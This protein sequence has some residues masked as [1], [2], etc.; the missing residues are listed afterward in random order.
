VVL[1]EVKRDADEERGAEL[2]AC[3]SLAGVV[4][5]FPLTV[6]HVHKPA[7]PHRTDGGFV[8]ECRL[9]VQHFHARDLPLLGIEHK[10]RDAYR[11]Y[12]ILHRNHRV[13]VQDD[14]VD[15]QR[16]RARRVDHA[17]HRAGVEIHP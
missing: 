4:V 6:R 10:P 11:I 5:F 15:A 1:H 2:C 9:L 17:S 13:A 14:A 3:A 16:R 8:S 12:T 7:T